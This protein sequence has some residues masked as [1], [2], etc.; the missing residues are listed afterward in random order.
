MARKR[1]VDSA[2]RHKRLKKRAYE[3]A[4]TA[5]GSSGSLLSQGP[6][7]EPSLSYRKDEKEKWVDSSGFRV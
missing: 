5:K 1:V 4:G 6:Y 3:N 2:K 7:L